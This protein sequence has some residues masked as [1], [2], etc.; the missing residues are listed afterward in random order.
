[1]L[2]SR[3]ISYSEVCF[4]LAEAA[5]KGWSV[6]SQQTWYEKGVQA[7]LDIWG[8]GSSYSSYIATSG[9]AY[10]GSLSQIMTQ[11]W[12][13]NWTVALESWFDWRRTGLP[14]LKFGARGR[15]DAMPIRLRYDANEKNRNASNYATAISGLEQTNFTAEDGNDSAWSKMWL[16]QG[17]GK[18]Y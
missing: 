17:T 14:I 15:R 9:V 8:V 2:K 4:I 11:K 13:A 6:G 18:P 5:N 7:S 12:L 16:I 1:M 3:L 10:D